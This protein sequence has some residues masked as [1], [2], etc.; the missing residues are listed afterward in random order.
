MQV[1]LTP[2]VETWMQ[3]RYWNQLSRGQRRR[4][5]AMGFAGIGVLLA[6]FSTTFIAGL[7]R[8]PGLASL[9]WLVFSLFPLVVVAVIATV[10]RLLYGIN[11]R[12]LK[13]R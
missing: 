10:A 8:T 4:W 12:T 13:R 9:G 1:S 7:A 6:I 2:E 11:V 5:V 3:I